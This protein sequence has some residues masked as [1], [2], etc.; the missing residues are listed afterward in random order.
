M[1]VT[2]WLVW[3]RWNRLHV[4]ATAIHRGIL[5]SWSLLILGHLNIKRTGFI[6]IKEIVE[7]VVGCAIKRRLMMC[8]TAL[9]TYLTL[10]SEDTLVIS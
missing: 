1:I 7:F 10:I 6:L 2:A 5:C 9:A 3:I 8:G 4:Q